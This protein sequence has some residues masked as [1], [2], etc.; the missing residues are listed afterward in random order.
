MSSMFPFHFFKS[1]YKYIINRS[2]WKNL[3][4][5]LSLCI[6]FFFLTIISVNFKKSTCSVVLFSF[7][8]ILRHSFISVNY[9]LFPNYRYYNLNYS[10]KYYNSTLHILTTISWQKLVFFTVKSTVGL[11]ITK[12]YNYSFSIR[13]SF[14]HFWYLIFVH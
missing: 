6:F 5:S 11:C 2:F 13:L 8:L 4:C 12:I 1:S 7:L 10:Y 3:L 9:Y 14:F